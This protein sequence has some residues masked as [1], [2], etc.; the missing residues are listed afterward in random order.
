V[1]VCACVRDLAC[2]PAR[3][4]FVVENCSKKTWY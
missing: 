2:V 4:L 3:V 1:C